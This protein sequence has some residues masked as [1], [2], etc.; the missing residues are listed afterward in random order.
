MRFC[1]YGAASDLIDKKYITA[2]EEL[3][4]EMARRG[5]GVVYGGG[6]T[7]SMGAIARGVHENGG[8]V[9]G[10]I[11]RFFTERNIEELYDKNDETI[12]TYTLQERKQ[13]MEDNADAFI[14]A[15]G[16]VGT[17]DE[18]FEA[19]T[20]RQLERHNK[21]IVIFNIDGFYNP[22]LEMMRHAEKEKFLRD[23]LNDLYGVCET[24]REV[25]DY[26]EK[27]LKKA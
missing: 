27:C 4:A 10:V 25:V 17:Y 14:I 9:L 5:Y 12:Y 15:P 8:N 2:V 21:P 20:L 11:P 13:V 24:P 18:F 16:G 23:G 6:N 7:G 19:L 26:L 22:L 3:G 1:L